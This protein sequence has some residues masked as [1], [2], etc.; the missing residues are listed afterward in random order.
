MDVPQFNYSPA[1]RHLGC[2]PFGSTTNQAAINIYV[3]VFVLS[4]FS[5]L[6]ISAKSTIVGLC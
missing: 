6:G 2:F 4:H 1:E 5:F 3:Q